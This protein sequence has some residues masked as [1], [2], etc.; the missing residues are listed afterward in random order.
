MTR[1]ENF[2]ATFVPQLVAYSV[3]KFTPTASVKSLPPSAF[4]CFSLEFGATKYTAF[5]LSGKATTGEQDVTITIC[6]TTAENQYAATRAVRS[7][8]ITT[9]EQ[10]VNAPVYIPPS[11][12]P[13]DLYC[14]DRAVL[15][16]VDSWRYVTGESRLVAHV[17]AKY[18][19]S[20]F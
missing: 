18:V 14:I 7:S 17:H 13:G 16:S 3:W 2:H 20:L 8:A 4:P 10:F 6:L 19:F 11:M 12:L 15:L 5:D 1:E 9:V